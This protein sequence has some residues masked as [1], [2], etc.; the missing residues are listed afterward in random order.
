MAFPEW[1]FHVVFH[2]FRGGVRFD[3]S[4]IPLW[5][6]AQKEWPEHLVDGTGRP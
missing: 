1:A 3:P 2:R 6:G 4:L 5:P